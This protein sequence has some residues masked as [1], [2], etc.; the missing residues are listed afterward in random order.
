MVKSGMVVGLMLLLALPAL[1]LT[2]NPRPSQPPSHGNWLRTMEASMNAVRVPDSELALVDPGTPAAGIFAW[3]GWLV[4]ITFFAVLLA[5]QIRLRRREKSL[6]RGS[7]DFF[8][9]S[10]AAGRRRTLR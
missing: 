1:G 4:A 10:P 9:L 6:L 7:E 5:Y 3:M 2:R 8:L